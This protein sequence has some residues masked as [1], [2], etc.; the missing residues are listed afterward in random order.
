MNAAPPV[1]APPSAQTPVA[2]TNA[3]LPMTPSTPASSP[4]ISDAKNQTMPRPGLRSQ[5]SIAPQHSA[6]PARIAMVIGST[7]SPLVG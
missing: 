3:A 6:T 2:S 4:P 1:S 5:P 7:T